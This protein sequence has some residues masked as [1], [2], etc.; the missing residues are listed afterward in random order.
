MLKELYNGL[1]DY[2]ARQSP[3]GVMPDFETWCGMQAGDPRIAKLEA[4]I[5]GLEKDIEKLWDAVQDATNPD[6]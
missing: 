5:A 1:I 2:M 4:R 6:Y 3:P